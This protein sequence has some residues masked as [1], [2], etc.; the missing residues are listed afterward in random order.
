MYPSDDPAKEQLCQRQK[1]ILET[2]PSTT[3]R[4]RDRKFADRVPNGF[5]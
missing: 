3:K 4:N 5:S 1:K 2:N